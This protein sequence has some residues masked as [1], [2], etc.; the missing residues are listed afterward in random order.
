MA[1]HQAE[2]VTLAPWQ[3]ELKA[4]TK[5]LVEAF[6]GQVAAGASFGRRQQKFSDWQHAT[7]ADFL[8]VDLVVQLE[9]CTVGLPGH[10]HVTRVLARRAGYQLVPLSEGV[11]SG[12]NLLSDLARITQEAG[13]LSH[14]ILAG[15]SDGQLCANDHGAMNRELEQ[16]ETAV[17]A[18]RSK[19][20]H[21]R[22]KA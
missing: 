14:A 13:D 5:G 7:I 2:K 9:G 1:D 20:H 4:A 21:L 22:G 8:P 15:L 11:V 12:D 6:G 18:M 3:Q 19:L 17:A 10:P 16:L